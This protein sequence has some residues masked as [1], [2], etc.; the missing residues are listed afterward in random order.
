[1]ERKPLWLIKTLRFVNPK[2]LEWGFKKVCSGGQTDV[3]KQKD[4]GMQF[5]QL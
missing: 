4:K 2:S 5:L 3:V 1:M